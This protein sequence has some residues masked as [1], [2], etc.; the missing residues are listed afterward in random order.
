MASIVFP[1]MAPGPSDPVQPL[2]VKAAYW[3]QSLAEAGG[4]ITMAGPFPVMTPGPN[5]PLQ[6]ALVKLAWWLEQASGG[7]GG[8]GGAPATNANYGGVAPPTDGSVPT[9]FAYDTS[10]GTGYMW[11][12]S[13][14]IASPTWNNV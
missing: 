9:Y 6:M 10:P 8:G 2:V 11:Y 7:G 1:T 13:G 12:N 3:A 4:A 5:D 14:T